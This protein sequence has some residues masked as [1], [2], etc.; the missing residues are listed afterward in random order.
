MNPASGS[1]WGIW[2]G[3]GL[4]PALCRN[5]A[6]DQ[7][8]LPLLVHGS[9][10]WSSLNGWDLPVVLEKSKGKVDRLQDAIKTSL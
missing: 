4:Q 7:G 5:K 8:F 3:R 2:M 9:K 6:S 10:S 1:G